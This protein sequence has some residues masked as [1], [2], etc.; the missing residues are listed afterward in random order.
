MPSKTY[1]QYCGIA[2]ALDRVGDRWTLLVLRELAFGE[3]RFTD[4]KA[5]LP[6]IAT[7]LLTERLRSL[8]EDGLVEQHEL[9]PPA[10]RSVYALTEEGRRVVPV[11]RA[12]SAFGQP[13][14]GEPTEG[15]VRAPVVASALA[16]RLDARAGREQSLKIRLV[17]DGREVVLS[18][19]DG[20]LR[21]PDDSGA[22]DDVRVTGS[23]AAMMRWVRGVPLSEL[24]HYLDLSGSRSGV[25]TFVRLFDLPR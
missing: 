20:Q 13:F 18:V 14:L 6:G 2:A 5:S 12:L 9:P 11:L 7:N 16:T 3:Q 8:E 19:D 1:D 21:R 22:K 10:A 25:R 24:A 17:L 23:A 4:L 15:Q